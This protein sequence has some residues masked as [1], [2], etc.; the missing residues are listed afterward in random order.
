MPQI[1]ISTESERTFEATAYYSICFY[2]VASLHGL[3]IWQKFA[4]KCSSS[5]MQDF[6]HF[7]R[8]MSY[9]N[10]EKF[11]AATGKSISLMTFPK[12]ATER[13]QLSIHLQN[14]K[15]NNAFLESSSYTQ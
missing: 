3:D 10:R 9:W 15:T 12:L 11:W 5:L 6:L 7:S 4:V 2:R 13:Y 14:K 1:C 8:H